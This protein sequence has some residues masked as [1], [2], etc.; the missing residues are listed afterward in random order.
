MT[1]RKDYPF[2]NRDSERMTNSLISFF[3][4]II[5]LPFAILDTFSRFDMSSTANDITVKN[6]SRS[7]RRKHIALIRHLSKRT[8]RNIKSDY[9]E[10][11][12]SYSVVRKKLA[13]LEFKIGLCKAKIRLFGFIPRFRENWFKLFKDTIKEKIHFETTYKPPVICLDEYSSSYGTNKKITGHILL[14]VNRKIKTGDFFEEDAICRRINTN[15]S[16]FEVS[17]EPNVKFT[18]DSIEFFFYDNMIL[19]MV[20][21][22]FVIV[23]N[24][25]YN[26]DY[27]IV[28][29]NG[30]GIHLPKSITHW[31]NVG[32]IDISTHSQTISLL[33]F[34]EEEGEYFYQLLKAIKN[35]KLILI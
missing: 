29:F 26:I 32:V 7:N 23:E 22:D 1:R 12:D 16:L 17:I 30:E 21:K 15:K 25:G 5:L 13:S 18:F 11:K 6:N 14:L 8:N 10:R 9:E 2:N 19:I 28:H 4:T 27:R 3:T 31:H 20:E 24:D 33:F 35:N 34:K